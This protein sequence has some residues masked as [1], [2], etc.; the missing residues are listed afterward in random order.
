MLKRQNF[1]ALAPKYTN[2]V[3]ARWA[4]TDYGHELIAG[5]SYYPMIRENT[6]FEP[7]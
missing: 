4:S 2:P 1:A 7:E 3:Y 5:I 6:M